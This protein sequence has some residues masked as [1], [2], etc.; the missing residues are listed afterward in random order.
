MRGCW[1]KEQSG[2]SLSAGQYNLV[3]VMCM[4]DLGKNASHLIMVPPDST[5]CSDLLAAALSGVCAS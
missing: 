2:L 1:R 4:Y 5:L 3:S